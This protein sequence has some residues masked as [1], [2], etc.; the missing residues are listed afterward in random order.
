MARS[1]SLDWWGGSERLARWRQVVAKDTG[2]RYTHR[3]LSAATGWAALCPQ[4]HAAAMMAAAAAAGALAAL[5]SVQRGNMM[6]RR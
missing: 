4:Q 1:R 3:R 6:H 5:A 2:V